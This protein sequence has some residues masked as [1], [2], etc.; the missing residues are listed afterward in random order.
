MSSHAA[1]EITE[2]AIIS[3]DSNQSIVLYNRGAEKIFGYTG[4]EIIGKPIAL[5]LPHQRTFLE[6]FGRRELFAL[7]KG[8]KEFPAEASVSRLELGAGVVFT[9]V[10]RDISE[11]KQANEALLASENFA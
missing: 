1:L 2:D 10:L 7:R 6:E 9:V 11:R 3:V 5:L 8:G 4:S